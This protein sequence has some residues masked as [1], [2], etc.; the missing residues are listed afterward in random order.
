M[1]Y[2]FYL[3]FVEYGL[4]D[5]ICMIYSVFEFQVKYE[6][7]YIYVWKLSLFIQKG[8]QF[9]VFIIIIIIGSYCKYFY[10]LIVE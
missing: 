8:F 6:R 4:F 7:K 3:F 10:L 9:M 5:I 2:Y 1:N